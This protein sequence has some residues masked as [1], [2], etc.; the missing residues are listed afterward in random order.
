[1]DTWGSN[2]HVCTNGIQ[3]CSVLGLQLCS[4]YVHVVL[5]VHYE[6]AAERFQVTKFNNELIC[7]RRVE[8]VVS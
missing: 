5:Y 8:A 2:L 3:L 4:M 7:F 1:M 6:Y